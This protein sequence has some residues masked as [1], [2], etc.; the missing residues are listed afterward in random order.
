MN[1]S[2]KTYA[3]PQVE[4]LEFDE[5]GVRLFAGTLKISSIG[6][7]NCYA[8]DGD[9]KEFYAKFVRQEAID[10][11]LLGLSHAEKNKIYGGFERAR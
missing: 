2:K 1:K 11:A 5:F 3:L 6:S 10:F 4:H 8:V 7:E 9:N